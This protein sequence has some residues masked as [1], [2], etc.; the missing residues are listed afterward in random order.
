LSK[1]TE[2]N[3]FGTGASS[4]AEL[5]SA[6]PM[7]GGQTAY[8]ATAYGPLPSFCFTFCAVTALKPGGQAIIA[9]ILGEYMARIFY[10]TAFSPDPQ[11]AAHAVSPW[12]GRATG[13]LAIALLGALHGWST[14]AGTRAQVVLTVFKVFALV[15][16]FVGGLVFLGLGKRANEFSFAESSSHPEGYAL[17]LFS[18]LWTFDG[19]DQCN[20]V[21]KDCVP[22]SLP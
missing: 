4:F 13:L 8:L 16:V 11:E 14:K 15:V 7:N 20:Y 2:T 17:A 18:A 3:L 5:G 6:L 21:S 22:G 1:R 19:W 10:H 9:V 12:V